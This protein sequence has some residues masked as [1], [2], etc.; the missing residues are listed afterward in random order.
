MEGTARIWFTP[1]QRAELWE[2]S[3]RR[4]KGAQLMSAFLIGRLGPSR[5]NDLSVGLAVGLTA[6]SSGHTHE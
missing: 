3:K 1:Q 2:R 5:W 4:S 6:G